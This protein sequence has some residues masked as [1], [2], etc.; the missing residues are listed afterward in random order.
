MF[1]ISMLILS[2]LDQKTHNECYCIVMLEIEDQRKDVCV[3][4]LTWAVE[5]VPSVN[6][7]S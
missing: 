5:E 4:R 6:Q 3:S 1:D 2:L 7:L